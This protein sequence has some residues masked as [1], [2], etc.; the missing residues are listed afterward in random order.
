MGGFFF[1]VG[2]MRLLNNGVYKAA[3]PLHDGSATKDSKDGGNQC[4]RRV[5]NQFFK[6]FFKVI[7]LDSDNFHYLNNFLKLFFVKMVKLKVMI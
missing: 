5:R 2:I 7:L 4:S 3:Y 6:A 1:K